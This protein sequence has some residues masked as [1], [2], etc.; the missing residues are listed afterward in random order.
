MTSISHGFPIREGPVP[1]S[2]VGKGIDTFS[3]AYTIEAATALLRPTTQYGKW[4][5]L[6]QQTDGPAFEVAEM[7]VARHKLLGNAR[8]GRQ[9]DLT[10]FDELT[11]KI[12]RQGI[13]LFD[14]NR[15]GLSAPKKQA[16]DLPEIHS[17]NPAGARPK[18]WGQ[19][20]AAGSSV[21]QAL[22]ANDPENRLQEVILNVRAGNHILSPALMG[23]HRSDALLVPLGEL[24]RILDF[25]IH[26]HMAQ[27]EVKGWFL[28]EDRRVYLDI[29]SGQGKVD[30]QSVQLGPD[31]FM[32]GEDEVFVDTRA[33]EDWFPVGFT[34]DFSDQSLVLDPQETLPFQARLDREQLQRR[35]RGRKPN[36]AKLPLKPPEYNFIDPMFVDFGFSGD[37][38]DTES[39]HGGG[40]GNYYLLGRGDLGFM[41]SELYMTGDENEPF[42]TTRLTLAR[43][44]PDGG[45]LGPLNATR[46][47]I[48][49]V[50]IPGFPVIDGG[51]YERGATLENLPLD[52]PGEYDTTFFSGNMAPGWDF[53]LYRNGMLLSS[54]RVGTKGRYDFD[55]VPLYYGNNEFLLKFYG[56][57]GQEKEEI[58]RIN[59]GAGMIKPGEHQYQFSVS[60][61]DERLFDARQYIPE[62]ADKESLRLQARYRYGL[63]RDLAFQG[64]LLSQDI[65]DE[66]HHYVNIG[67]QGQI[68]EA[69]VSGDYIHDL[70]GGD[71]IEV[72]G[73]KR[74]GNLDFRLKQQVYH[75]FIKEGETDQSN[76]IKYRTDISTFG[77]LNAFEDITQIPFSLSFK[78][79]RRETSEERILGARFSANLNNTYV[80]NYLQYKDDT[81]APEGNS[82]VEGSVQTT[83]Q[84]G[85]LRLRTHLNYNMYPE[86]GL[87]QAG[88]SGLYDLT[89][90]LNS[91]LSFTHDME[92]DDLTTGSLGVNWNNGKFIL[93]PRVS[94]N[95]NDE[96]TGFL[97]F[98][99]S[100]GM[101][102]RSKKVKFSSIRQADQGAVS[103]RVFLDK[104]SN[105]VFDQGDE[106]LEGA[107]VQADQAYKTA[108]TD[109]DGIGFITGLRK[110]I[111][112]DI[113]LKTETLEDPFWEPGQQGK[114]ILPRPGH[115]Q[116]VDI[117][118]ITTG[119]VDGT[120]FLENLKGE[121]KSLNHA[122]LQLLDNSGKVIQ[123]IKSEYDGFYLFM[124]VPPGRYSV[125]LAPDFEKDLGTRAMALLPVTIGDDGTV[126]NGHDLVFTYE[127]PDP[128]AMAATPVL[129]Q[130]DPARV[131]DNGLAAQSREIGP[132]GSLPGDKLEKPGV[133]SP[134]PV[135][136]ASERG[137]IPAGPGKQ[138]QVQTRPGLESI[139]L[140]SK[141]Q[142]PPQYC[143][144]SKIKMGKR[145]QSNGCK[146]GCQTALRT[147]FGLIPIP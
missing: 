24:V 9:I 77:T 100:M 34:Y 63:S 44:D 91:E 35:E 62:T 127:R 14:S 59:V 67:A 105:T 123:E 124:K 5:A 81:N 102:P 32:T 47:G 95:S 72:T 61:K 23:Y 55:D 126:V 113:T 139:P 86:F 136:Q 60:Q 98:S 73:Q 120:L 38:K 146:G 134:T 4:M 147:S 140:L 68:E 3:S 33:L 118:V 66:T 119:E 42:S 39:I 37:Y 19:D 122:P 89:R 128:G 15:M 70:N 84:L 114:S 53:E 111:P 108:K 12:S 45:L 28:T 112:T 48:G 79:T 115:V 1:K 85:K 18:L 51:K 116:I 65:N 13:H 80:N 50:R 30:G 26:T 94:Y 22:P 144:R 36:A 92:N 132:V 54:Q 49:D 29:A 135:S 56:P 129:A 141:T 93:S 43:E 76:K 75:N 11:R 109:A 117:P 58:K 69:Y 131:R 2:P 125:R 16:P 20:L 87:D 74:F 97:S 57:Q 130:E 138:A 17:L 21:A 107:E 103:A 145:D 71:A 110:N 40:R 90:E 133:L 96:F 8:Q 52:M 64:G 99:T 46:I 31:Q 27:K 10:R 25:N 142:P 7:I 6:R 88:V 83:S 101:E 78:N 82:N 143:G 121:K 106:P 137:E 41:N 104:N